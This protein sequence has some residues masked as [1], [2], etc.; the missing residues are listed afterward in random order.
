MATFVDSSS[1]QTASSQK[2]KNVELGWP[3]LEFVF[4]KNFKSD[5]STM[6]RQIMFRFY[7]DFEHWGL[8]LSLSILKGDDLTMISVLCVTLA[9]YT[10]SMDD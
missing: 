7:L 1:G 6:L 4:A 8:P 5:L 2:E 9:I 10:G 3:L